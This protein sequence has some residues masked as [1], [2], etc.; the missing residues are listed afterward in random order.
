MLQKT[1]LRGSEVFIV[2]TNAQAPRGQNAGCDRTPSERSRIL[3]E[4]YSI[5]IDS[6]GRFEAEMRVSLITIRLA[7]R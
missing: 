1:R 3:E 2:K 7:S 4:I 5:R 6:R